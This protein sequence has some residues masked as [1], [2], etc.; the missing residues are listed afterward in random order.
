MPPILAI[1]GISYV[2]G[3]LVLLRSNFLALEPSIQHS[4]ALVSNYHF[5]KTLKYFNN[6]W[7]SMPLI[8][9]WIINAE[10]QVYFV[11]GLMLLFRLDKF[12]RFGSLIF[13]FLSLGLVVAFFTSGQGV[14]YDPVF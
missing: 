14:F 2:A 12:L 8:H 3:S 5:W 7:F 13:L 6:D 10:A 1:C 4:I 9:L 11:W